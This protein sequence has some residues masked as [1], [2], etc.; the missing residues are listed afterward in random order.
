VDKL[1]CIV[2]DASCTGQRNGGSYTLFSNDE[3][4]TNFLLTCR[5]TEMLLQA[6]SFRLIMYGKHILSCPYLEFINETLR[7]G[8][9]VTAVTSEP[10]P[11]SFLQYVAAVS[12]L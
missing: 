9:L 3:T 11:Q 1:E 12:T 10:L 8:K 4:G 6:P 2:I 7:Q 5:V